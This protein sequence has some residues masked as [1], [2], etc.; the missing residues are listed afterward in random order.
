MLKINMKIKVAITGLLMVLLLHSC[1]LDDGDAPIINYQALPVIEVELPQAFTFGEVHAIPVI[2]E[3]TNS[4][5]TFAGFDVTS[6]LNQR[7]ITVVASVSDSD[8]QDE[9]IRTQQN[10][11]FLAAS[12]G[13]Y[14]F[15]FFTGLDDN[16]EPEYLEYTIPV[17]E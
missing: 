13:S 14:V 16:G 9:I 12:N 2:F 1:S 3:Y 11:R 6:N 7:E 10:L 15:K 4:C 5:Q 8:C 17:E